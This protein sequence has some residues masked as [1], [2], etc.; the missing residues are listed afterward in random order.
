ML[1]LSSVTNE[2]I[3]ATV[4]KYEGILAGAVTPTWAVSECAICE[5]I[6]AYCPECCLV[7]DGW[8][9]K[10]IKNSKLY[11]DWENWA[12]YLESVREFLE[13]VEAERLR[14]GL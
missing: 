6:M 8:C 11:P 3:V 13:L 9:G 2:A 10:G 5:E 12:G 14:R 4:R 7:E 1:D